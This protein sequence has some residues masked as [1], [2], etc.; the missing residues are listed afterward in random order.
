MTR[1]AEHATVLTLT[2]PRSWNAL[3]RSEP[4]PRAAAD[5][6]AAP[7]R[8]GRRFA[9]RALGAACRCAARSIWKSSSARPSRLRPLATRRLIGLICCAAAQHFVVQVRAGRAAGRADIADHLALPHARAGAHAA[10]ETRHVRV[11]GL[12]AVG[13]TDAHVIA[14]TSRTAQR[15]RPCP[16]PPPGSACRSARR[17]RCR[18]A[19]ANSRGSGGGACR[20]PKRGARR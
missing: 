14:V 19:C 16:R 1:R 6:R 18:G 13:V 8:C 7:L 15:A 11:G 2:Q 5:A 10:R 20:S 9:A 17:N 3:R 4:A 12:V